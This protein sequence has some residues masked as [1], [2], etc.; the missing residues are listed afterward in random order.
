MIPI[1]KAKLQDKGRCL[2]ISFRSGYEIDGRCSTV[3]ERDIKMRLLSY[4]LSHP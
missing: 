1:I 4:L 3:K 2:D